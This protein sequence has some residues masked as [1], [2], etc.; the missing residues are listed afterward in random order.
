MSK[1]R[2]ITKSDYQTWLTVWRAW[3]SRKKI[4]PIPLYRWSFLMGL[5]SWTCKDQVLLRHFPITRSKCSCRTFCSRFTM[6]AD[7]MSYGMNIA[8]KVWRPKCV[9]REG[10][11]LI[12]VLSHRVPFLETGQKLSQHYWAVGCLWNWK[13]FS[14]FSS[15]C[16]ACGIRSEA[17]HNHTN[18]SR[19]YRMRHG[20]IVCWPG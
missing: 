17:M 13:E 15:S 19:L 3:F 10:R 5:L 6:S 11:E 12:D 20:V 18:V 2:T 8:L 9:A 14:S 16:D 4:Y 7:W 1:I